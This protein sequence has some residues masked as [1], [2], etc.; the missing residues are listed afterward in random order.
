MMDWLAM[1]GHGFYIWSS[2]ALTAVLVAAELWMLKR[3]RGEA[4]RQ[5][6]ETREAVELDRQR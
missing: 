1:G 3:R 4:W 6:D 5:V 2:Y